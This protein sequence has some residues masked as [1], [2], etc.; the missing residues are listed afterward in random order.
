MCKP[1]VDYDRIASNYDRR[2]ACSGTPGVA[3]ALRG[4]ASELG[5]ERILEAGCG[6]G[7]W[8][9]SL[10][11]IQPEPSGPGR[12]SPHLCGLDLS[13][14]MV[15]QARRRRAALHLVRGRAGRL[16]FRN[17]HFDLVYCVNAVHH[18]DEPLSFVR[19]AWRLLRPGGALA[20]VGTDP[21]T[22]KDHWYVYKYFP[23]TYDVDLARF[24]AWDTIQ[25]WMAEAG[26][27][28]VFW[29][30]VE[31]IHD[32]KVGRA[33]LNDPFLQK[34]AVSQLNLL[35]DEAYQAGLRRIRGALAAAE[36]AG[37]RLTCA[38]DL[39]L[40]MVSGRRV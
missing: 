1:R 30:P 12:E 25:D 14:G 31:E 34:D 24:P 5:A 27:D 20:I 21:R 38:T 6:T 9:E 3:A 23:G 39:T 7:H 33:V 16:P 11:S 32:T 28:R 19:E 18:F 8:L 10:R 15:D 29:Q 17:A 26:F 37:E 4:L 36:A 22:R 40:A 2:Y 13:A 35:S